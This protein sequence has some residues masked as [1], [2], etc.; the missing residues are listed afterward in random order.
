MSLVLHDLDLV[1]D[2]DSEAEERDEFH[3]EELLKEWTD[4]PPIRHD[5]YPESDDEEIIREQWKIS[6][7]RN[8]C[9][10]A[11]KKALQWI[12][13][14]Y[15]DQFARL[16]DYATEILEANK[17]S[18]VEVE[19]LTSDDGKDMFNRFYVCFDSLR[20][21][22]KES[23][24]PLI[25]IDGC[26]LKNKLLKEDFRLSD[27]EGFIMILD[28]QK[29]EV[30]G[31]RHVGRDL[32]SKGDEFNLV[33][34]SPLGDVGPL[35][36]NFQIFPK[37]N[38]CLIVSGLIAAVQLELPK[39]EHRM[40]VQHIYGNS[41]KIYGSKT[42]IKPLL[43]NLAWSY[44]E[45]EYKQHLEKIRCYDTKVYE[46]VMKTKPRSWV[47]AFQKIGSFCEDVDNNSVES[48]NG[49]LNKA[50]EKPFV[51]MLETIRRMAMVRIAKRS[52]ESHT[53]TGV[54]TP[55]VTKF[56][57]GEHKVAA[58]AKVSPSTNGM[59]E[60]RHGGDLHRVDLQA[61]T[62]TCIKW[63]I[64][65]IPCEHAYSVIIH[66]KLEPENF[67]C[68]WFRTAMWRKNYT[69]GL[70]PQRGPKFWPESNGLRVYVPPP[71]EGEEDKK[72]TKAEKKRKKGVN[73]SP[74]KKQPKGKKR[75]MHCGVCGAAD[76]NS[77]HH[78]KDKASISSSQLSQPEPSQGSLTQT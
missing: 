16:R 38:V 28:R 51:A 7:T 76:H 39:I 42:M 23:C 56:L 60:V 15:D 8:Q 49:S 73:E 21:T 67:V 24:R 50:R 35:D 64:C 18:R 26:F 22:W 47:R 27:G 46:S 70:F 63:Q 71:T 32:F 4:E 61:Y 10:S 72:M 58:A 12:E 17:D 48:F 6:V 54:C 3:M 55:Y 1:G 20:R 44:N 52:V 43:W 34:V 30:L 37:K 53:H 57:A 41:K 25:G 45:K 78:R 31:L 65:G 5:M 13:K 40:C 14:E 69:D 2:V 77:R 59:Y 11:R 19:C 62:C 36:L 33:W 74:T 9:Q 29:V 66:K 68:C 75:I